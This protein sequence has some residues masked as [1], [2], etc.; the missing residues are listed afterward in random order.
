ML[1]VSHPQVRL[2]VSG[3]E[4]LTFDSMPLA[5]GVH[6]VP[7]RGR[8]N[9]QLQARVWTRIAQGK[10]VGHVS[11]SLSQNRNVEALVFLLI[12]TL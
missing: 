9:L 1:Q 4:A 11:A 7:R 3:A 10:S 6:E 5:S 8:E 2:H 12:D